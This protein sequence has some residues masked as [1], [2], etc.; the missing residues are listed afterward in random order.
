M[1]LMKIWHQGQIWDIE[2]VTL[3]FVGS[4]HIYICHYQLA[5]GNVYKPMQM[6]R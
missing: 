6:Q 3:N 4:V 2:H 1:I 5:I